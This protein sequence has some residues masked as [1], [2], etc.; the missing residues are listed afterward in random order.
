MFTSVKSETTYKTHIHTQRRHEIWGFGQLYL[1]C[2]FIYINPQDLLCFSEIQILGEP[3]ELVLD[4]VTFKW[5][6]HVIWT[7][8]HLELY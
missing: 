8:K 2:I 7:R 6:G 1:L 3:F 5:I 4:L